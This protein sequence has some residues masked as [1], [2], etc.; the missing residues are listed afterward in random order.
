MRVVANAGIALNVTASDSVLL[1]SATNVELPAAPSGGVILPVSGFVASPPATTL[2]SPLVSSLGQILP[3][4]TT[5]GSMDFRFSPTALL[6]SNT[7]ITSTLYTGNGSSNYFSP[8]PL[9][10]TL[11]VVIGT[12][13]DSALEGSNTNYSQVPALSTAIIVISHPGLTIL[14]GDLAVTI[15]FTS[16]Q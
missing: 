5:F 4:A 9:A 2:G 10:V 3:F 15:T 12:P 1:M 11:P 16:N 6:V 14:K 7:S 13:L 8:S